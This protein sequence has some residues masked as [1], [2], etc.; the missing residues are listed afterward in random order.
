QRRRGQSF[1]DLEL[2]ERRELGGPARRQR[3]LTTRSRADAPD[4]ARALNADVRGHCHVA[5]PRSLAKI[6]G[7]VVG[8]AVG[9]YIAGTLVLESFAN[10]CELSLIAERP[11]PSGKL[12]ARHYRATNCER[13][14]ASECQ[15]WICEP[16]P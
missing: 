16:T 9:I 14:A 7:K 10:P 3:C 8:V 5:T 1:R 11:S 15:A 12:V 6:F 13:Q 4:A 2:D